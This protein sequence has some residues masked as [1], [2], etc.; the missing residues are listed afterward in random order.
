[1]LKIALLIIGILGVNDLFAVTDCTYYDNVRKTV[2]KDCGLYRNSNCENHADPNYNYSYDWKN[3]KGVV[4][5]N[6]IGSTFIRSD[7]LYPRCI[8]LSCIGIRLPYFDRTY[9]SDVRIPVECA[10]EDITFEPKN[11]INNNHPDTGCGSII[12]TSNKVLG[13]TIPLT[14]LPF[15]LTYYSSRVVGRIIDYRIRFSMYRYYD[16]ADNTSSASTILRDEYGDIIKRSDYGNYSDSNFSESWNGID[17]DGEETWGAI[18]RLVTIHSV[19]G[20]NTNDTNYDLFVGN[21]KAKKLGIGGWAPSIWHFYDNSAGKIYY[22]DGSSRDVQAVLEGVY[23][24]VASESGNEVYYFDSIGRIVFT[25]TGLTGSLL[26]TFSYDPSSQQLI[27]IKDAFNKTTNFSYDSN[28]NLTQ[29]TSSENV[30]T[31]FTVDAFGYLATVTNPKNETYSMTYKDGG[32]L[33]TNFVKPTGVQA[34]FV[35]D[36]QGNLSQDSNSGGLKSTLVKSSTGMVRMSALGRTTKNEYDDAS[37]KET[38]T[39]PSG[40]VT[41]S[42]YNSTSDFISNVNKDI[43]AQYGSDLR[44]GNQVKFYNKISTR[45]FGNTLTTL[46]QT[47]D[48]SDSSNPFSLNSL[49]KIATSGL[50]KITSSYDALTRTTTTSTKLGRTV[51]SQIDSRERPILE[52]VGTNTPKT[53]QYQNEL[54]TS[55]IEGDRTTLLSYTPD[56]KLLSSIKN[57]IGQE[58]FFTYDDAQRLTSKTLPDGRVVNYLYDS[59]NNLVSITPSGRSAH[60]LNYGTSEQLSSY[61]PPALAG[62]A[63]VNTTYLYSKDKELLKVTRPDGQAINFNYN[64]VTGAL[65]SLTGAFGT[66]TREYQYEQLKKVTNQ[67]MKTA[68]FGYTGTMPT[69]LQTEDYKFTRTASTVTLGLIG[70]ETVLAGTNSRTINYT[71]D[72]DKLIA[73]TGDLNLVHNSPNGALVK[74]TL[75]NITETYSYDSFGDV[76]GFTSTVKIAGVDKALYSYTLTR[77][78]LGRIIN[79]VENNNGSAVSALYAYDSAGR[80]IN[81]SGSNRPS[82]DYTYD[83]NSNRLTGFNFNSVIQGASTGI[84]PM[85]GIPGGT[86]ADPNTPIAP[87]IPDPTNPTDVA[88]YDSQDR[89]VR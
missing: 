9:F 32:G 48:L 11:P 8:A 19:K 86:I 74:T 17:S 40:L 54:L 66:I 64:S 55:I 47:A 23:N 4:W 50:S 51:A 31:N 42:T 39:S 20:G 49:T 82:V 27:N 76:S 43:T 41:T 22:G 36:Q 6:F 45:D 44:F 2:E 88:V 73:K 71:Y 30:Q 35:Y 28:Q 25:K 68:T 13:E 81:A 52:Q 29:I 57:P 80:L 67:N 58:E 61:V 37:K 85:N 16:E 33:L 18:K 63:N 10:K 1:M 89:L 14:G 34:T 70:S 24:R 72:D 69:L 12:E 53:Y 79:K 75:D 15:Y 78:K 38:I 84:T 77:D 26:Y 83:S 60:L 5:S 87:I 59:N 46:Q 3:N 62:V 7:Y 65:D 21:L 56:T